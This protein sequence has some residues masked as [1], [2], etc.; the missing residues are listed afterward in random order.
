[1]PSRRCTS[2]VLLAPTAARTRRTGGAPACP[3]SHGAGRRGAAPRRACWRSGSPACPGGISASTLAS[4]APKRPASTTNSTT[5]T[6]VSTPCT[7]RFSVRFSA[8]RVLGLEARRVDEDELR[9]V[10]GAD[11][12]DAVARGLRLAR[13]DADLL[14][15]QRVQQRRLADVGPADDG[16]QA[17]AL[18][19]RRRAASACSAAGS[20]ARMASPRAACEV[21]GIVRTAAG[22]RACRWP[23]ARRACG[24]RLPA[25]R[26]GASGLRRIRRRF[27]AGTAHSTSKVCACAWPRVA[28]MR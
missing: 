7:V 4:S 8:A 10:D 2:A 21:R 18:R 5:S 9:A 15:D 26:R 1:M 22:R 20:S 12:G 17:A 6:S 11:A 28:V 19:G 14:A 24:A 13:G 16:H 23:S 3:C 25:R 27:S